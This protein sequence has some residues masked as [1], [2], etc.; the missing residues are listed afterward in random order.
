MEAIAKGEQPY[1]P[2]K[3]DLGSDMYETLAEL[4][5]GQA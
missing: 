4:A 5:A 1:K 3:Y 2:A